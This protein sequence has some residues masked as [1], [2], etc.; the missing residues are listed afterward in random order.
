MTALWHAYNAALDTWLIWG[1][2]WAPIWIPVVWSGCGVV[3][4]GGA[5][6]LVGVEGEKVM[7][8]TVSFTIT[9]DD[10]EYQKRPVNPHRLALALARVITHAQDVDIEGAELLTHRFASVQVTPSTP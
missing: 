8:R 1:W 5:G 3:G 9:L 10:T 6:D 2:M 4:V 7:A